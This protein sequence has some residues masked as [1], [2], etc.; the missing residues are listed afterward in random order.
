MWTEITR[1]DYERTGLRYTSDV[2]DE[3]WSH[4]APLLM[5]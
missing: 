5:Y 3:E 1:S 4:V 2:T